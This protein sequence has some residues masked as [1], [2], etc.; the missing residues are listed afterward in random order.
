MIVTCY[1]CD[2]RWLSDAEDRIKEVPVIEVSGC[3]A[4]EDQ[5]RPD[6]NG[7]SLTTASNEY[8]GVVVV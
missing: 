7:L 6:Q 3:P 8:D 1:K 2:P 5:T 4:S